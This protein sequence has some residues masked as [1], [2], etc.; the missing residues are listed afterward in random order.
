MI[1]FPDW[2]NTYG[3]P[4]GAG[5]IRQAPEDFKVEEVL[6]FTP[7]GEGEHLFLFIEKRGENT[8]YVAR[9]LAKFA[10]VLARDVGYAGL[11]DRQAV[12]RQWFSIWLPGKTMPDWQRWD[13]E[14]ISLIDITRHHKK[15]KR[16]VLT[17][18]RF[19]LMIR[20]WEGDVKQTE[21]LL[22]T[23]AVGGIANYYGAQRFGR[24][25][26]N[27]EKALSLFQGQSFKRNQRSL[28]LSAARSF[29]FNC[30]LARRIELENWNQ[31][32]AGDVL[33]FE[34]SNSFFPT[35]VIDSALIARVSALEL[36][37]TGCL[38]G[39]GDVPEY[40]DVWDIEQ[41]I[42]TQYAEL[43][44][45]LE[46]MDLKIGRRALRV[47]VENFTWAFTGTQTLRLSFFLPAGSY[48]TALLKEIIVVRN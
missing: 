47:V 37:P 15:L 43:K 36:H 31:V 1:N 41:T 27:I 46:S 9:Q 12:T 4:Q 32:V 48:A 8:D 19:S 7:S 2:P 16:G 17:G 29:L 3:G 10:G 26:K 35:E 44:D 39:L 11:K 22:N 34:G 21:H 20:Q 45:G 38:W 23:I 40:G 30:I 14:N 18:N 33:Q 42:L 24:H 28:Y 13:Q 6:P 25:G 5:L